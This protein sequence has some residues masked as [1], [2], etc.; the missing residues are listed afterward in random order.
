MKKVGWGIIGCGWIGTEA[1]APSIKWSENGRVVGV[2]SR[3][4]LVARAKADE[5]EA[6]RAYAPYEAMLEDPDIDAVYIGLPNGLHERW[7]VLCAQAGKH[8]LCEKSLTMTL[9]SALRM[10][11]AFESRKLRL[12][13]AF[14]YR[15]HPQWV[16]VRDLIDQGA[17]GRV[18]V[19]R[20]SFCGRFDKPANHRWSATLGGGALWDLTCYP[21]DAA[22]YVSRAEAV[23]AVAIAD[24]DTPDRVDRSS[25]ASI[26]LRG[27]VLV[28]ATGSLGAGFDQSLFVVGDE[29]V[30]QMSRPFAPG[31]EP[32]QITLLRRGDERR[33]DVSG[34]NQFLHQVE[35]FASLVLD[36]ERDAWP[37]ENGVRN[38]ATCEAIEKSWRLGAAVDL[39]DVR[40]DRIG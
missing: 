18:R 24:T 2:A 22:R 32:T 21:V 29:G 33:F 6:E 17:I 25:V 28:S 13:E 10:V 3:D 27:G 23:R 20:G 11:S 15:H 12:V 9:E 38:V 34:A 40:V 16:L 4:L 5:I 36:P 8:V 26:E 39:R 7:A 1:I 31:W 35:H 30:L 19:I 14:M 37:A